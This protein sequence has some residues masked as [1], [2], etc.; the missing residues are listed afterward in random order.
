MY[1]WVQCMGTVYVQTIY[2]MYM[3]GYS[4]CANHIWY[5]HVCTGTVYVHTIYVMYMYVRVQCMCKPYIV[6]TCTCMYGYSVRANHT[7]ICYV[8]VCMGIVYV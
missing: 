4:V 2:V 7:C 8:H 3:D 1:V 6:C 5:V